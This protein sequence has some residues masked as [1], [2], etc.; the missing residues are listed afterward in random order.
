MRGR[1]EGLGGGRGAFVEGEHGGKLV[2]EA[3]AVVMA[4]VLGVDLEHIAHVYV[5]QGGLERGD[6]PVRVAGEDGLGKGGFEGGT[7]GYLY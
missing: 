5:G 4:S 7:F 6:V 1:E 3:H 2:G